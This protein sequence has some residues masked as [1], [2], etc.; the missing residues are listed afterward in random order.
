[1]NFKRAFIILVCSILCPILFVHLFDTVTVNYKGL[2]FALGFKMALK[3]STT[4]NIP[5]LG[6]LKAYTHPTPV[7]VNIV[8]KNIDLDLLKALI[9]QAPDKESCYWY[10]KIN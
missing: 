6:L 2:E 10:L 5:P 8:L 7:E 9:D 4:V 3:G 1:M